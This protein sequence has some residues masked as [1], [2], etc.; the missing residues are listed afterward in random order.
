MPEPE[1]TSAPPVRPGIETFL[2][3]ALVGVAGFCVD[4]AVLY[5]V[6]GALGLYVGRLASYF[7][8]ATATWAL[9]RRFT[10]VATKHTRKFKQWLE[11]LAANA[12]GAVVNYGVYSAAVTWTAAAQ[13]PVLG[14]AAGSIAGLVFNF[15]VSKAWVFADR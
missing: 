6:K 1:G 8:A 15:T 2:R 12:V 10:F 11:F 9:N 14:V 3:F 13:M 4:S 5:A 7:V